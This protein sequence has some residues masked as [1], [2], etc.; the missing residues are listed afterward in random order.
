MCWFDQVTLAFT[1]VTFLVPSYLFVNSPKETAICQFHIH[2]P[3]HLG[4]FTHGKK[5]LGRPTRDRKGSTRG[6]YVLFS[7]LSYIS[8][9]I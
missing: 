8:H 2:V 1:Y 4:S 6:L 3:V 7:D 5:G 9:Y